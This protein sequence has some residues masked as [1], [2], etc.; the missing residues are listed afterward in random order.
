MATG[1]GHVM[2]VA[3][4]QEAYVARQTVELSNGIKIAIPSIP[5]FVAL[6]LH[7]WLDRHPWGKFKDA[8]DIA[9]V[10]AWYESDDEYLYDE[11]DANWDDEIAGETDLMAAAVLGGQVR[12]VLGTEA[13]QFLAE[14]FELETESALSLFA[15]HLWA[16]GE[17]ALS[18]SRRR[19][20]V[21]RLIQGVAESKHD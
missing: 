12:R 2:N 4:F 9:L 5:G 1:D 20:Q 17:R 6:K 10:L 18:S 11:F 8:K 13:A 16:Q 15:H 3:G 14:R 19:L 7:A 21:E